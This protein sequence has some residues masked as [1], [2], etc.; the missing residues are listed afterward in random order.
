MLAGLRTCAIVQALTTRGRSCER[1]SVLHIPGERP[2]PRDSRDR[3]FSYLTT[4]AEDETRSA[5]G[6]YAGFGFRFARAGDGRYRISDVYENGPAFTGGFLRGA[7][8]LAVDRGEGFTT[9][10]DYAARGVSLGDIFGPP[11]AGVERGFRLRIEGQTREIRIAKTTLDVPPI[12]AGPGLLERP[13]LAPV[14]YF[15]MR[16]FTRAAEPELYTLFGEFRKAGVTDFVIDLRYNSGG[17]LG[18]TNRLLDLLN[19]EITP[20]LQPGL[21]VIAE[22]RRSGSGFDY[23]CN[24]RVV[25]YDCKDI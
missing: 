11:R 23:P 21:A 9:L 3:G 10:V 12:A 14:G 8:L 20:G 22:R 19:G 25:L 1:L 24:R 4:V 15:H 13:G 6:A 18:V 5:T 17:N 7:E 2:L 16:Q